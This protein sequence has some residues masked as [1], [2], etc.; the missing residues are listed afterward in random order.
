MA[1]S[2][3]VTYLL[4]YLRT[5]QPIDIFNVWAFNLLRKASVF[6]QIVWQW[7]WKIQWSYRPCRP[8]PIIQ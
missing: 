2:Y 1:F 8:Q 4:T 3:S 7:W 6:T 5:T